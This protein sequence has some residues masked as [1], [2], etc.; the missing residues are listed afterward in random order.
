MRHT[1]FGA[2]G[3]VALWLFW[4]IIGDLVGEALGFVLRPVTRPVWRILVSA[5]S[6]WPLAIMLLIGTAA[7]IGSFV[8]MPR[9]TPSGALG[10]CLFFGGVA[11]TLVAPFLWRDARA[12]ARRATSRPVL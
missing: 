4:E 7:V 11:L 10:L 3:V 12:E 1:L 2:L 8:L 6:P 9:D 5:R